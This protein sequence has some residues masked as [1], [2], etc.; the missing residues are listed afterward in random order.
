DGA[1]FVVVATFLP[2]STG[3]TAYVMTTGRIVTASAAVAEPEFVPGELI[4]RFRDE[5]PLVATARVALADGDAA[6]GA[7]DPHAAGGGLFR[8]PGATHEA[9]RAAVAA[10]AGRPD[11]AWAQPNYI[12]HPMLEPD[13]QYYGF[14]WH[15]PLISLPAAWDVTTGSASVVVAVLD[16]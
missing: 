1:A 16:T 10:L 3:T 2:T 14:Q 8:L 7:G 4:V 9:T 5:V 12:R 15:Y 11:V 13:D 6:L